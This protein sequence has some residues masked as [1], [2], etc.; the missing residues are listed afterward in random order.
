MLRESTKSASQLS[1]QLPASAVQLVDASI[2]RGSQ[3]V[4]DL[5]DRVVDKS[6]ATAAGAAEKGVSTLAVG[7]GIAGV[8]R[9]STE[10]SKAERRAAD[11]QPVNVFGAGAAAALESISMPVVLLGTLVALLLVLAMLVIVPVDD[12]G[13][14]AYQTMASL[15]C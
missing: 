15:P 8:G 2:R 14:R 11:I 4:V 10:A 1:I 12:S 9:K 5:A 7:L 13:G 3:T 6:L